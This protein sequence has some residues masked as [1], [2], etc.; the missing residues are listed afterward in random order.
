MAVFVT[1]SPSETEELATSIAPKLAP[2]TVLAFF[3]G[4]GMGKTA[5]A[6]MQK[7][8]P[9]LRHKIAVHIIACKRMT[10][11]SHMHSYL[12]GPAR[13]KIETNERCTAEYLLCRPM[14]EGSFA[15]NLI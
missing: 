13:L 4:M 6:A 2:G 11:I 14:G 7:L 10:D 5:F 8:M 9:D 12:M 15:F 1:K 3:G